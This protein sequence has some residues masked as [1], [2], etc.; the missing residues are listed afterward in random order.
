MLQGALFVPDFPV[1]LF[2]VRSATDHGAYVTFTKGGANLTSGNTTFEFIRQG[3]L[4]F[5]PTTQTSA[6]TTRTL[7]RIH[8]DICGRIDPTSREGYKYVINFCRRIF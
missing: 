2:S 1:S 8:P 5:L 7:Y 6:Y 3:K 4:Y